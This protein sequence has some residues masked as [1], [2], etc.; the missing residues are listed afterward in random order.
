MAGLHEHAG[1]AVG[2]DRAVEGEAGTEEAG[3]TP[4]EEQGDPHALRGDVIAV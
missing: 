3:M 2:G 1:S 4:G